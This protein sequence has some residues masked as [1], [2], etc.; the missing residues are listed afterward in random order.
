MNGIIQIF[1]LAMT[2]VGELRA[3]IPV[4]LAVYRLH[5]LVVYF[6]AVAGNLVPAVLLLLIL[7]PLSDALS[8]R[9]KWAEKFFAWLF[10]KGQK[11]ALKLQGR[12]STYWAL[13]A[14][15]AM[16]LPVTG[17]WTGALVS[18]VL[19]LSFRK[20]LIAIAAGVFT[21]GVIVTIAAKTGI[22]IS[23]YFGWPTLVAVVIILLAVYLLFHIRNGK[24]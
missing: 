23:Q 6:I 24:S 2:P 18:L 3:A 7:K 16:P 9:T 14:F 20:S 11:R 8:Q 21:A 12:Q 1:L 17:A 10:N 15:V 22:A 4:G 19:G 13:A 5:W